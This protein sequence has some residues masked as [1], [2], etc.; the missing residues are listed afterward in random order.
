MIN[1][2]ANQSQT[3]QLLKILENIFFQTLKINRNSGVISGWTDIENSHRLS[4]GSRIYTHT[5]MYIYLYTCR[6][7]GITFNDLFRCIS[8][9]TGWAIIELSICQGL[10]TFLISRGRKMR[11]KHCY[12]DFVVMIWVLVCNNMYRYERHC[13]SFYYDQTISET[14]S[15][16]SKWA[17]T[18]NL[19][20][21]TEIQRQGIILAPMGLC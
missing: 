12:A 6:V 19:F 10:R 5:H 7:L 13:G 15:V 11:V 21:I 4:R 1:L 3:R 18:E 20:F 17:N 8:K 9:F 16:V 2:F 14:V